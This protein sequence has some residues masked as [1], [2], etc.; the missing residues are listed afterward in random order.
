MT[1]FRNTL[2]LINTIKATSCHNCPT[3]VITYF[4]NMMDKDTYNTFYK[5]AQE[6]VA[7]RIMRD[8]RAFVPDYKFN[9]R[10]DDYLWGLAC[11]NCPFYDYEILYDEFFSEILHDAVGYLGYNLTDAQFEDFH[12]WFDERYCKEAY[13]PTIEMM[14]NKE[15]ICCN[16]AVLNE[17][18]IK[19]DFDISYFF[20]KKTEVMGK[21]TLDREEVIRENM[22][23]YSIVNTSIPDNM[24]VTVIKTNSKECLEFMQYGFLRDECERIAKLECG[25]TYNSWDYSG[26]VVVVRMN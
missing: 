10:L 4:T 20:G 7:M 25:E 8:L 24:G 1:T 26:G 13:L 3:E 2:A 23:V 12:G 6:E 21:V 19:Y 11:N 14:L 17:Y 9:T 16:F 5:A 18:C 22:K 15:P